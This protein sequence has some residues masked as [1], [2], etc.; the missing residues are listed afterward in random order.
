MNWFVG[1]LLFAAGFHAALVIVNFHEDHY[2]ACFMNFL[3]LVIYGEFL[4]L[5]YVIKS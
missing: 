4:L 2:G 5:R 3:F 1:V